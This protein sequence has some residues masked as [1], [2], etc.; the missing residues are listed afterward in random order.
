MSITKVNAITRNVAMD[1]D[2]QTK[3]SENDAVSGLPIV[4]IIHSGWS[5]AKERPAIPAAVSPIRQ[6]GV[7]SEGGPG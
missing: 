4:D 2:L 1:V 3:P 5:A 7:W 6:A